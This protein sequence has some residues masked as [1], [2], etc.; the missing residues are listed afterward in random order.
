[1]ERSTPISRPSSGVRK[2][3][4]GIANPL[5]RGHQLS[6]PPRVIDT[7]SHSQ[8]VS[9]PGPDTSASSSP[10]VPQQDNLTMQQTMIHNHELRPGSLPDFRMWE[11]CGRML[12][13][14]GFLG[15]LPFPPPFH[16][17][18][19]PFSPQA[20]SSAIKT[21]LLTATQIS[22]LIL[23]NHEP[24]CK[25][26]CETMLLEI[27]HNAPS[28]EERTGSHV[29]NWSHYG[30]EDVS[31][32]GI[33]GWFISWVE[34]LIVILISTGYGNLSYVHAMVPIA[35]G[36][37]LVMDIRV[38]SPLITSD[39]T[40]SGL[41]DHLMVGCKIISPSPTLPC[42]LTDAEIIYKVQDNDDEV[43]EMS[44]DPELQET[45]IRNAEASECIAKLLDYANQQR[46]NYSLRQGERPSRQLLW[47]VITVW[48]G[49]LAIPAKAACPGCLLP[50]LPDVTSWP[51]ESTT[52]RLN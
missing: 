25:C 2:F 28:L 7:A 47:V 11:S 31:K 40:A 50:P 16:S 21:L 5:I 17:S 38:Q 45:A 9:A 43:E 29:K 35:T 23:H 32:T 27:L 36:I 34:A 10:R 37:P 48:H 20:P 42:Q 26:M 19:A 41:Q 13:V 49:F 15:D 44:D 51:V 8:P 30:Q 52:N 22:S 39:S 18:I 14:A 6:N 12:L 4:Y 24:L 46:Y 33:P 1:M 3:P